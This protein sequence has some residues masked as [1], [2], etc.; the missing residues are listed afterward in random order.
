MA[1]WRVRDGA[2][3]A[4]GEHP[5]HLFPSPY[6]LILQPRLAL[7]SCWADG[8]SAAFLPALR[9]FFP[10]TEVQPKGLLAT[11]GVVTTPLCGAASPVLAVASHFYEFVELEHPGRRPLLA[12]QLRP[13]GSYTP[14]LSTGGGLYRYALRDQADCVG[15]LRAT[16]LLRFAGKLDRVSDLCGEKLAASTVEQALGRL[17]PS[18]G[19]AWD[20]ALLA[21]ASGEPT[22]YVLLLESGAEDALLDRLVA[23]LDAELAQGHH[24]GYCRSLGQ[25]APLRWRRV[26]DGWTRF[27]ARLQAEGHRAGEVKPTGLDQRPGWEEVL[28]SRAS[29]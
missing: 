23:Q 22:G 5:L 17:G 21:P 20:F 19:V 8:P 14:L 7:I 2:A 4:L 11:K 13:G 15:R 24:Y 9:R 29:P 28:A 16:P 12:H 26:R 10:R 6:P 18:C 3:G 25:L 1:S 27:Q